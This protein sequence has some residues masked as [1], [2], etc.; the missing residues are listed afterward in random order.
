MRSIYGL[1]LA[2]AMQSSLAAMEAMSQI[3]VMPQAPSSGVPNYHRKIRR[4]IYMPH[5]GNRECARRI[6][7]GL[8]P[9]S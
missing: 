4:S 2:S 5:Q 9:A 3:A 6:R 8:C 1:T 7:Q